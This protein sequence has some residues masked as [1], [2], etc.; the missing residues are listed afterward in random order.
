MFFFFFF[1][2]P[3]KNLEKGGVSHVEGR[4]GFTA[5]GLGLSIVGYSREKGGVEKEYGYCVNTCGT[6]YELVSKTRI[7]RPT[8]C[9]E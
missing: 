9:V 2:V 3:F 8:W 1:L 5:G 6:L 4:E 7:S